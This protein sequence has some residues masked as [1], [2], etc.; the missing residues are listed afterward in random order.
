MPFYIFGITFIWI[1][2]FAAKRRIQ[3]R[4]RIPAGN[5]LI[6]VFDYSAYEIGRDIEANIVLRA[7]DVIMVPER[8][9]FE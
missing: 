2:T 5:E 7:G 6:F 4:R 3:V 8:T 1:G 9:L